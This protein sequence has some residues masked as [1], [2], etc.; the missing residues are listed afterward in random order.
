VTESSSVVFPTAT[1]QTSEQML[2]K[3]AERI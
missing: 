1:A 3:N 2:I